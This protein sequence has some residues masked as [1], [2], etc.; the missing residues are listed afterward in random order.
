MAVTTVSYR[1]V[2]RFSIS[3]TRDVI[4]F[5]SSRIAFVSVAM[6]WTL[7]VS[8]SIP[9]ILWCADLVDC[10]TAVRRSHTS[11]SFSASIS[12]LLNFFLLVFCDISRFDEYVKVFLFVNT[13]LIVFTYQ[14]FIHRQHLP[15][16]LQ[17]VTS[18]L[19]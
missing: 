7:S 18:A 12:A 19:R 2:G 10:S 3:S 1:F 8:F 11:F 6:M 13:H 14:C 5:T 16:T 17:S 15:L 9:S 4:S